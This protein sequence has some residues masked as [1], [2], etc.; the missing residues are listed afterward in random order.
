MARQTRERIIQ[1]ASQG[2]IARLDGNANAFAKEAGIY[3][4]PA[5]EQAA[6]LRLKTIEPIR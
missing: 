3:E 2:Y 4:R 5:S 6:S 1:G